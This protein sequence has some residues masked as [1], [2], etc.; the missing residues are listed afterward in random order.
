[1]SLSEPKALMR[2]WVEAVTSLAVI[3]DGDDE[4]TAP[5]P[6][7]DASTTTYA[8]INFI[9]NSSPYSVPYE[10]TSDTAGDVDATKVKQ[11]RSLLRKGLLDVAIYGPG[12]VDYCRALELSLGRY[13]TM[14]RFDAAGDYSVSMASDVSDEPI[15]RAATREPSAS[16]QFTVQWIDEE[17]YEIEAVD[18]IVTTANVEGETD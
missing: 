10:S 9:S 3:Y 17:T 13:D 4:P 18:T 7:V 5:R 12:A 6:N 14:A 11:Y 16:I 8:A 15:L 2:S 1:M